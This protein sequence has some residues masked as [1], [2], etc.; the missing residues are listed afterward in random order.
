[1]TANSVSI[2]TESPGR[3][4][5]V[6]FGGLIAGAMD[7]TAAI[8]ISLYFGTGPIQV[9]Q[10]ITSGLL[11]MAAYQTGLPGAAVG[12]FFQFFIA[13]TAAAVYHVASLKL[14]FLIQHAVVCGLL[15]GIAVY[16]FM[17]LVVLPLS[18]FPHAMTYPLPRLIRGLAVHMLCV[19]LPIS[20]VNRRYSVS[21]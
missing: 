21:S 16:A 1:M 3:Y 5:P 12:L 19:G 11:G 18:A 20:L 17:N 6:L 4:R 7:I 9:L 2:Y 8:L 13:T 14:R 10:S 15:Y